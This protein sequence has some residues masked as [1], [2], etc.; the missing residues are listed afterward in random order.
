MSTATVEANTFDLTQVE[1]IPF[2][3]VARV[4]LRKTYDTRAGWWLLASMGVV[5]VIVYVVM[6]LMATVGSSHFTY[7][8]Y[9]AGAAFG[10]AVLLPIMGILLI[11]SEWSQ[12]TAMA[13]F[14][15]EPNRFRVI[16]AKLITGLLLTLAVAA[17]ALIAG[18]VVTLL[19][20]IAGGGTSWDL[21]WR[22]LIGFLFTQTLAML[23]GFAL[24]TLLL[25]SPAAIVAFFLYKWVVP[26]VLVVVA[27]NVHGFR[28]VQPW[29]DFESAQQPLQELTLHGSQ[30]AHLLVTG[31]VWLA[32][33]FALGLR[34]VFRAEVK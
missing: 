10:T 33:P 24:A 25:N 1:R 18:A 31:I 8:Q 6:L 27:T 16:L 32:V 4:E 5:T 21:G 13:T 3:R 23:S 22:F 30:W 34:R 20:A 17:F 26:T 11:T 9:V 12:R 29:I 19:T 14:S 28:G 15:L 7:G 2:A